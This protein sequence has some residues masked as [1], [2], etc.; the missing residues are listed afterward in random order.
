MSD[1]HSTTPFLFA[2]E[3]KKKCPKCGKEKFLSEFVRINNSNRQADRDRSTGK[4]KNKRT[5]TS[6]CKRCR[7]ENQEHQRAIQRADGTMSEIVKR[8]IVK[9]WERRLKLYGLDPDKYEKILESQNGVCAICGKPETSKTRNGIRKMSVDHNHQ[10]GK[11]RSLLCRNCNMAIGN[12]KED[13]EILKKAVA[14]L[15]FHKE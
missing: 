2:E 9:C 13:V 4:P 8:I 3:P 6:W 14:Y 1:A 7:R 5:H 10:T 15:E 12:F 11:V